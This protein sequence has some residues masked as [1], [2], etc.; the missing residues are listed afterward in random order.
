MMLKTRQVGDPVLRQRAKIVNDTELKSDKTQFLIDSMVE[1]LRDHPGVGIAAPQLGENLQIIVIEDLEK[2]QKKLPKALLEEQDR[3]PVDLTI[4]I[5]P[6]LAICEKP[7]V[8]YFEGCLS[9][10]GFRALVHRYKSV[11]V[12][13][14]N[15]RGS[16]IEIQATGWFARILQHEIDHLSGELYIDKM[17]TRSFISEKEFFNNWE[18]KLFSDLNVFRDTH[19]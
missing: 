3:V 12:T 10:P 8:D 15:R 9:V 13:G 17:N 1:T 19:K 7:Q 11:L 2:Y 6:R 18:D 5:N 14:L 4:L 16:P